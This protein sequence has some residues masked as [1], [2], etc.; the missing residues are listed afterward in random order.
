MFKINQE[1][2]KPA[3]WALPA[4]PSSSSPLARVYA[5]GSQTAIPSPCFYRFPPPRLLLPPR[6]NW[7]PVPQ[8]V[9]RGRCAP[10]LTWWEVSGGDQEANRE[11]R[12]RRRR[13]SET[14]LNV[15]EGCG[16]AGLPSPALPAL[17]TSQSP[18]SRGP[19]P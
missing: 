17:P 12:R 15:E 4:P 2:L 9:Q 10:S 1:A 6:E 18:L 13:C 14:V 19:P 8:S 7:D 11:E 3:G 5:R 16:N